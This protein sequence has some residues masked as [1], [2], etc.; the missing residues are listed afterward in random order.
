M[1]VRMK[2]RIAV[3]F[4]G[5]LTLLVTAVLITSAT[6]ARQVHAAGGGCPASYAQGF[7]GFSGDGY[8]VGS[9][10][11][12][13]R[14][15]AGGLFLTADDPASLTG[16]VSGYATINNLG[17]VTRVTLSGTYAMFP[18]QCMGSATFIPSSGPTLH[19]DLVPTG[20]SLGGIAREV[21]FVQTDPHTTGTLRA[22]AM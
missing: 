1:E 17:V 11:R 12:A 7:F 10:A 15:I 22:I 3:V 19:Y 5:S 20:W 16:T 6:P 2:T 14:A 8:A 13:P 21:L 18:G 9:F 4:A